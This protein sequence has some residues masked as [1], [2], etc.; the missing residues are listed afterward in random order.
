MEEKQLRKIEAR[1]EAATPGPWEAEVC[2]LDAG[3]VNDIG[4]ICTTLSY[5]DEDNQN[6]NGGDAI[7]IAAARDDVPDLVA[8]VRQQRR[9]EEGLKQL[10][11]GL[12]YNIVIDDD[13]I[14]MVPIDM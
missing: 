12:G 3:V 10:I 2:E 1:C 5:D 8:E 7:F 6:T 11:A 4:L 14:H 13:H 9:R